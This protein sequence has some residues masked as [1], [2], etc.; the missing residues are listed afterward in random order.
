M[1][2]FTKIHPHVRFFSV[3][4]DIWRGQEYLRY[5][6]VSKI[7]EDFNVRQIFGGFNKS[8]IRDLLQ[9]F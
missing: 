5:D 6:V 2:S 9:G 7:I 1:P 3:I 4:K 8:Q